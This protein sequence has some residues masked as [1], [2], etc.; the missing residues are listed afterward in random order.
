[1]PESRKN[2]AAPYCETGG[3]LT[4]FNG[5]AGQIALSALDPVFSSAAI[6]IIQGTVLLSAN[7]IEFAAFSL[8]YSYIVMGQAILSSLFGGPLITLLGKI[9]NDGERRLAGEGILHLQVLVSLLLGFITLTIA[10]L[11][12]ID[13]AV[14][15]LCIAS[16]IGLSY[17]DALRSVLAAQNRL[18][19]GLVVSF[20]FGAI[21]TCG[22]IISYILFDRI[23][24]LSGLAILA[25]SAMTICSA[26]VLKGSI[27]TCIPRGE[28][29]SDLSSMAVWSLPGTAVIW[30]QNSFY[31]TIIALNL[32]LAAV[33]EISAA[34]MLIM[35]VLIITSG[36]LRLFQVKARLRLNDGGLSSALVSVRAPLLL[37]FAVGLSIAALCF[38]L[39]RSIVHNLMPIGHG[40]L[41][42]L[43]GA[44]VLFATVTTARGIYSALFQAMGCYR[45]IFFYNAALLP[46][47]LAGIAVGP[48]VLGLVG[49]I[50]PMI[51]GE[52]FLLA[53]LVWRAKIY[54]A[55]A[56]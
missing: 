25:I 36:M 29:L 11:F 16:F 41:L 4:V 39:D 8:S 23:S 32:N 21:V 46:F 48:Q 20:I 14:S 6:F 38:I 53:L 2:C 34:R 37:C 15:T 47:V 49:A 3:F 28:L 13:L 31:L 9:P 5:K 43:A 1:M 33:G 19:E 51:A 7:K 22:L 30:L 17:R 35:P 44:W 52:L 56:I 54:H 42:T 18:V 45:E 40:N 27:K 50:L 12:H 10:L 26:F 24:L 55:A